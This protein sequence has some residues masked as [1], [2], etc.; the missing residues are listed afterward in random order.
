MHG[1]LSKLAPT[2]IVSF[3]TL[4]FP[5]H[6]HTETLPHIRSDFPACG[7]FG[8]SHCEFRKTIRK[9]P[10][11]QCLMAPSRMNRPWWQ[12]WTPILQLGGRSPITSPIALQPEDIAV[13]LIDAGGSR[14]QVA[15]HF[16]E[17]S[18]RTR[19]GPR[20]RQR[21][22]LRPSRRYSSAAS[23]Q[24][25][26]SAKASP[27]LS[28]S[29]PAASS[30]MARTTAP[31]SG[32]PDRHR[33][34]GG[35]CLRHRPSRHDARL[36]AGARSDLQIARGGS[37]RRNSRSRHRQRRPRHRRRA[38]LAPARARDRHRRHRRARR[39][40]QRPAQPRRPDDRGRRKPT[41]SR[42]PAC[43]RARHSI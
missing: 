20:C 3:S 29:P 42:A 34:R 37:A 2:I 15:I 10:P 16:R 1:A 7:L 25:T 13:S 32:Q 21:P 38:R 22:E 9:A 18:A 28:R 8:A 27:D 31:R 39:A 12:S 14:W 6:N 30:S 24:P 43:Q 5:H 35:A 40:R 19:C 26:G 17:R 23:R 11:R 4:D 41:A 36:S 33:N